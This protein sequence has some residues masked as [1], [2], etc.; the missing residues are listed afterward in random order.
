MANQGQSRAGGTLAVTAEFQDALAIIHML[1][2]RMQA[3]CEGQSY[4]D[5]AVKAHKEIHKRA[6]S[7]GGLYCKENPG[8]HGKHWCEGCKTAR[9]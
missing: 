3:T 6:C 5:N 2:L 1:Y 9:D 4:L 8:P 7:E